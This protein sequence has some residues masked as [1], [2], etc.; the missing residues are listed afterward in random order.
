[1]LTASRDMGV[2]GAVPMIAA[3]AIRCMHKC[4]LE[5]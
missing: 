1:M 5:V 3:L 2:L 4:I